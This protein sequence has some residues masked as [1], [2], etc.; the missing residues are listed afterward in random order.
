MQ[1][2]WM[3]AAAVVVAGH[4]VMQP[5]AAVPLGAVSTATAPTPPDVV[6]VQ[7]SD[8]P[9]ERIQ[10]LWQ[11]RSVI[12]NA[13]SP[14]RAVPPAPQS[15]PL[16]PPVEDEAAQPQTRSLQPPVQ[17]EPPQSQTR[18][19]QPP[20][21]IAPPEA[22][23]PEI[24]SAG[25]AEGRIDCQAAAAIVADYGFSDVRSTDCA[26]DLYAFSAMRDGTAYA[27]SVTQDGEI[28]E[29]SRQ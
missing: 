25:E 2:G 3:L 16:Q 10:R 27:L 15:R 11:H 24:A 26:G 21:E 19:L 12:E 14:R 29:V 6:L 7:S 17:A 22:D 23:L 1:V 5:A 8:A 9:S 28:A 4:V 18:S 20:T 13:L